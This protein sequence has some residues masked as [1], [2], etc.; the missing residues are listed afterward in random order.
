MSNGIMA[1][2]KQATIHQH[3]QKGNASIIHIS[4][5][6]APLISVKNQRRKRSTWK[7][8]HVG[9]KSEKFAENSANIML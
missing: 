4:R 1:Q 9:R 8:A 6:T 7:G 2:K 3:R 5:Q